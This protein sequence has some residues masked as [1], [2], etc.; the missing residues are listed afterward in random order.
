MLYELCEAAGLKTEAISFCSGF[1]SQKITMLLR[2]LSRIHPLVGWAA[3]LPLR[4]F[5]P[6]FD[7]LLTGLMRYQ[8]FSICIEAYK[9]RRSN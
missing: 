7:P 2:L 9:P 1:L 5:P 8:H 3:I 4:I 6:I